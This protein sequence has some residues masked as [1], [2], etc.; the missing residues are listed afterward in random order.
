VT[1]GTRVFWLVVVSLMLAAG[2]FATRV[3]GRR[4][5]GR[6]ARAADSAGA[7]P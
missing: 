2:L 3:E 4:E 1:I 6:D 5:R 7:T